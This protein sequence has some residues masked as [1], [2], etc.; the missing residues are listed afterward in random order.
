MASAGPLSPLQD[1]KLRSQTAERMTTPN[2]LRMSEVITHLLTS[3][4][5]AHPTTQL[6]HTLH[7][8]TVC[9]VH[10]GNVRTVHRYQKCGKSRVSSPK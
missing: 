8:H 1:H 4:D 9:T 2:L 6:L 7:A 3:E 10:I 5:P